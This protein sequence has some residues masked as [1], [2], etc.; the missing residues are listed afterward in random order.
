LFGDEELGKVPSG[1]RA[2]EKKDKGAERAEIAH[3]SNSV[4]EKKAAINAKVSTPPT[5]LPPSKQVAGAPC[6]R[7]PLFP[8][9]FVSILRQEMQD[10]E[11]AKAVMKDILGIK[12]RTGSEEIDINAAKKR[13]EGLGYK[14]K[15]PF[16]PEKLETKLTL[17]RDKKIKELEASRAKR[18]AEIR[19]Q[20]KEALKV[21]E[22]RQEMVMTFDITLLER[23][24]DL[25]RKESDSATLAEL[26]GLYESAKQERSRRQGGLQVNR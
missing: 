7:S 18:E 23:I 22:R 21:K 4:H 11:E 25:F 2:I 24:M 14:I 10:I 20:V 9:N 17:E 8:A 19:R 13:L 12:E 26:K 5:P 6:S 1:L 16:T 3:V 15:G